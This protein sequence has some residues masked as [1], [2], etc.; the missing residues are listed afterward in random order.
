MDKLKQW[1]ALTVLG[2]T[3]VLAGGWFLLVGPERTEAADLR[4]QAAS[5]ES[6]NQSL[7]TQL[8]VLK[9]QAKDLPQQKAK[10]AAIAAKIPDN[11][12]LPSLI[13]A[14]DAASTDAGV[15]LLSIAPSA[16]APVVAAVA[17]APVAPDAPAPADAPAAPVAA[18]AAP[19]GAGLLQ[20]VPLVID[21]VGG[22]FEVQQFVGDLERLSRALRITS[23]AL[24][25]GT[26]PV[27]GQSAAGSAQDG[28]SLKATLT[29][30][31]FLV[32]GLTPP[33]PVAV[34]TTAAPARTGAVPASTPAPGTAP[35][36]LTAV[37]TT[38]VPA[39]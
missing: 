32:S 4:L 28:R 13:R 23:L 9:A 14:L 39:K 5:A 29:G 25:P 3:A 2:C 18:P 6:G 37:P 15:E 26:S 12:A 11:P 35:V 10:L 27:A 21:V 7:R 19:A 24:A 17:A 22:Y 36:S 34:A 38:A 16:P 30:E 1:V 8:S 33:V 31:V 20:S